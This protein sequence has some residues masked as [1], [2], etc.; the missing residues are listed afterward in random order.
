MQIEALKDSQYFLNDGYL[1]R[2]QLTKA[3]DHVIMIIDHNMRFLG[4]NFPTPA[5]VSNHYQPMKNTEWTNGFWT[6]ML[7]LA[8]EYT[9]D[10]KYRQLAEKNV[11]SF[12]TRIQEK[13]AVD[14]HDLGFLYSPATVSA[15]KL[16]GNAIARETSILAAKQ[17]ATR[18]QPRGNFIQA[19]GAKGADDN[20]RLIID[21]LLNIPLL[22]WA[23]RE[24]GDTKL[25]EMADNHYQTAIHTVFRENGSTYHTY[26]FD[27]KTG[28]PKYGATHQ[29]YSN[30]SDWARGQAWGIYGTALHYYNTHDESTFP[31]FKSV[32]NYYLNRLPIDHVPFWDMIF[33]EKDNQPRDSS[34]AAIAVC[35]IQEMLKYL[36][37]TDPDNMVYRM[38]MHSML[39]SLINNYMTTDFNSTNAVPLLQHGVYS[40]HSGK[41]VDEGNLWG[42]YFYF[43]ALIRFYKDWQLYW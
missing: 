22:Y 16:T 3:L 10:A 34:S 18:F 12:T 5:T 41:G 35:G 30:D 39:K 37:E 19:W 9:G 15:Y 20:Y 14:H 40:W 17:L 21:A 23:S 4:E 43:E 42:D 11:A 2:Q 24:S 7:W 36:P 31:I 28:Q 32:T 1:S 26:F 13:I 29:G 38:A 6:G 8:Y 27:K 25:K 33:N